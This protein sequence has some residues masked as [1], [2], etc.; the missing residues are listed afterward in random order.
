M[1]DQ[2]IID[3]CSLLNLYA[4]WGGLRELA[5]FGDVWHVGDAVLGEA[6]YIWQIGPDGSRSQVP[7]DLRSFVT[8][9]LLNAV[10][11]ESEAEI[12]SYVEFATELDDGEAQAL[13]IARHR[14]FILLTD[15]RKALQIA[16][17]AEIAVTTITTA[18]ILQKWVADSEQNT[19]RLSEVLRNIEER[20][21]FRPR[22]NTP[23]GDWWERHK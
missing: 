21:R 23:D 10:Q 13:A 16:Q 15:E 4:G 8:E 12:E 2:R 6:Q 14:G 7:I 17:R 22:Q 5:A 19:A 20:A 1:A 11:P 9:G 18:Q 3:C